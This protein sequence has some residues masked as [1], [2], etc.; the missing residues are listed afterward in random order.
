MFL[1]FFRAI[2]PIVFLSLV[3]TQNA[4]AQRAFE[5][6]EKHYPSRCVTVTGTAS[7]EGVSEEFARKMALRNALKLASMQH[8]L[9]VSSSEQMQDY[10]LKGE[11]THFTSQSKVTKFQIVD[12]G[13]KEV[14]FNDQFDENGLPKKE[15][16]AKTYQVTIDAC[17]TEDPNA[18]GNVLGNYL[19]P[20]LAIAQVVTTDVRGASDISN[21]LNGYQLELDRRVKNLGY[22]NAVMLQG[23]GH[24][25]DENIQVFPNLDPEVLAPVRE[26]TGAQYALFTVLRSLSR[27][28]EQHQV[29]KDLKRFYNLEVRPNARYIELDSYVVDLNNYEIVHQQRFGLDVKSDHT[30]VGRTRPFGSNAF[31]ATDTGAAFH[32]LLEQQTR[33]AYDFVKCKPLETQIIDIRDG[34]YILYLTQQSGARVGDEL[35]VYHKFGRPVRYQNRTLG[36]DAEPSGFLKIKR[37]RSKFAVAEVEAKDGLM[38]IGDTVRSW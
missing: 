30:L 7:L 17:V 4:Q 10:A 28:N 11:V 1:P 26:T 13:A 12:E 20:R 23:G 8:N 18:C 36:V 29:M 9:K 6:G 22:R 5:S 27:H 38:E 37:I 34:E 21:L 16:P 19:Q 15:P 31:F 24:I 25:L 14:P 33:D 2:Y 3:S 32:A 35:T